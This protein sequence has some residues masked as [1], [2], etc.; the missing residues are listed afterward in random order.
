MVTFNVLWTYFFFASGLGAE[1]HDETGRPSGED[2]SVMDVSDIELEIEPME[3]DE[4]SAYNR[5]EH[6]QKPSPEDCLDI[7]EVI[8]RCIQEAAAMLKDE[9]QS[10]D[11]ATQRIQILLKLLNEKKE[12]ML[13]CYTA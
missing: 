5:D 13:F 9:E 3:L 10:A 2:D 6:Q 1:L 11:R 12:G 7:S 4:P 8:Y